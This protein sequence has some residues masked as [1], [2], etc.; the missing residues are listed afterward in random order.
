MEKGGRRGTPPWI[1]E[2]PP[3][4]KRAT[5]NE[6]PRTSDPA[7]ALPTMRYMRHR[8]DGPLQTLNPNPLTLNPKP[9]T[10]TQVMGPYNFTSN[11]I[12]ILHINDIEVLQ[13]SKNKDFL[14]SGD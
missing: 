9:L 4:D 14:D 13:T 11:I 2:S 5:Q 3:L 10:L 7:D 6:Y 12:T 8:G 1:L